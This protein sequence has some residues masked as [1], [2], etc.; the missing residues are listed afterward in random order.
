MYIRTTFRRR[1]SR[2]PYSRDYKRK[3]IRSIKHSWFIHRNIGLTSTKSHIHSIKKNQ[4]AFANSPYKTRSIH[5]MAA[6]FKWTHLARFIG[7]EDGQIHFGQIDPSKYPDVGLAILNGEKVEAKLIKGSIFDGVV[8]DTTV[9]IS[10][11][12]NSPMRVKPH[13]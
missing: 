8:T 2:L 11:V 10:R 1:T 9:H 7:E 4:F 5:T 12:R 13:S 6:P 3:M